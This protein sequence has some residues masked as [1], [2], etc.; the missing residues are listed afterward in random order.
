MTDEAAPSKAILEM[1][2][3]ASLPELEHG[4]ADNHRDLQ[5]INNKHIE[6]AS[7]QSGFETKHPNER[8][9]DLFQPPIARAQIGA[10]EAYTAD[11]YASVIGPRKRR[12][13]EHAYVV[14]LHCQGVEGDC[15]DLNG[16][17]GNKAAAHLGDASDN[18]VHHEGG[19]R[20]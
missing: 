13:I 11:E 5:Y 6:M 1:S 12:Q 19:C 20:V 7:S 17:D 3:V 4:A 8:H 15:T 16:D 14:L 2:L 10:E 9:L 18:T